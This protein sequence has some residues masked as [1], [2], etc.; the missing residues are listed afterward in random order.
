MISGRIYDRLQAAF[1][2]GNVFYDIDSIPFGVD[3]RR[4][5]QSSVS[6]CYCLVVLIGKNWTG[7]KSAKSPIMEHTDF[8]RIE[9]ELAMKSGIHILPVL[10]GDARMPKENLVPES[11]SD[12][13]YL[14]AASVDVGRNFDSDMDRVIG[15][16]K[17][18]ISPH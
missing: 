11:L 12:F 14:N 7:A 1:G 15:S 16:I 18:V 5:I 6:Q 3:F 17:R 2:K 10:I 4:H 13:C 9:I 8:V